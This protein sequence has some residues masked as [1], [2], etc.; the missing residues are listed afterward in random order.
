MTELEASGVV[1]HPPPYII[2]VVVFLF[3][4]TGL[5]GFLVCHLLKKKGYRLRTGD[6]DDEEEE[7]KL[8]GNVEEEDEEN[9]DTVE[10]ILKCII[11][12]EANMEAFNEMF[13]N[14]VH[15]DP[16][17]RKESVGGVPPHHHTVHSGTDHNSCHLCAQVRSKKGRR[18]SRT[19]RHKQRPGEQTVFSVGR[20][21]VTHTDKKL[22]GGPN[23][24][25]SSGD[26]LDQSQDSEERKEGGYNLRSMFK[27]SR[28]PS[29]GANGVTVNVGKRRKSLTIFGLR[30]GSDP[31]GIKVREGTG[32][33]TGGVKF[34]IKPQ[35]VVL[36]ELLQAEN[37]DIAKPG[38]KPETEASK[39]QTP[40][41]PKLEA[42]ILVSVNSPSSKSK[43]L[44]HT[45]ED[46][47]Q[48][49]LSPE[50]GTN[51]IKPPVVTTAAHAPS[52]SPI[53]SPASSGHSFET[54]EKQGD[55]EGKV[56]KTEEAYDPGPLQT[57]TPIAPLP[58][59]ITGFTPVIPT[60]QPEPCSSP[61]FPVTQTPPNP[62]STPDVES[63]FGASLALISLGSSPPYSY[64]IK[65][66]PSSSTLK[67]PILP[68]G[69]ASS[70]KLSSRNIPFAFASS[71][72]LPSGPAMYSQATVP[73]LTFGKSTSPLQG[74]TPLPALTAGSKLD[75]MP[76]S[77]GPPSSSPADQHLSYG[78]SPRLTL[79]SGSV[80]SVSSMTKEDM[81]SSPFSLKEQELE[82][83]RT[84]K[85]E[86]KTEITRGGILKTAKLL[87]VEGDSKDSALYS[88]ND[89]LSNDTLSSWPLTPS[90]PLPPS[91]PIGSNISSVTIVKASPDSKRE[92]S[93]V[94]M[95]E[96]EVSS[97][98][99]KEQKGATSELRVE[100]EKAGISP[101]DGQGG[102]LY[103]LAVGQ[104]ERQ[105]EE[106]PRA[107][108]RPRV[109][110]EKDDIVE[111][112]DI[113]DCK[114]TQVKEEER[115]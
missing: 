13:G 110:Q 114:V 27:D 24:L 70:P 43:D 30:R 10:Q 41:S 49:R 23:P 94:T 71:P 62:S 11:E 75:T 35:S 4:L 37:I 97:T 91:S 63:G 29:E 98:S 99:I 81:I 68:V 19:P 102:E 96:Q 69:I 38:I 15:H 112:E 46:G 103:V 14:H 79:K 77:P 22:H 55:V 52:S 67:M 74:P 64:S 61:G 66:S 88:P 36:E 2:F 59:S 95:M 72:K 39:S 78:S 6:M 31:V 47:S 7:K 12:N 87:P 1:D 57:S 5:L 90:C 48:H 45:P 56:L 33:E 40:A 60:S 20:F 115:V 86:E 65:T 113:R 101:A 76:V 53:P 16:R 58:G 93:V 80:V 42:K 54:R 26:Q 100:S 111:M 108:V 83:T 34:T 92:F 51:Q 32:R 104:R 8:G 21:R 106:T 105:I 17:L 109:I 3:F 25:V 85:M 18:Q 50:P 84:A 89:Q 44:A 73:S 9:Q 107:E 28:L 82:E